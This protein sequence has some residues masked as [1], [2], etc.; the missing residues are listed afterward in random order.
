MNILDQWIA[1]FASIAWGLPLLIL[2]V[3][4][5]LYLLL[6]IRALPLRYISHAVKVLKGGYVETEAEGEI[7]HFQALSTALASTIGMVSS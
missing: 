5:G 6:L 3:G 7:S 2:L 4:G 1:D